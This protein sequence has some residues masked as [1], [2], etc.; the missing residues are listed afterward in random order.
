MPETVGL[1]SNIVFEEFHGNQA[2]VYFAVT[3]IAVLL[4]F[5]FI[6]WFEIENQ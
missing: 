4:P 5:D 2:S 3:H 1:I 6:L